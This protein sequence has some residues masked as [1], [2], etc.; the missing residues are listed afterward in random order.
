MG[1]KLMN[2]KET[3]VSETPTGRGPN[4]RSLILYTILALAAII[5]VVQVVALVSQGGS[6]KVAVAEATTTA[7]RPTRTST[8]TFTPVPAT[9]TPVPT[10][11]ATQPP[12]PTA[13][14]TEPT[15]TPLPATATPIPPTAAPAAPTNTPVPP[16]ATAE[17]VTLLQQV[18]VNNGE[19]GSENIYIRYPGN[20]E[21][22]NMTVTGNDGHKYQIEIGFLSSPQSVSRV[23]EVWSWASRGGG[24]WRMLVTMRDSLGGW[25]CDDDDAVCY[26]TDDNP[27]NQTLQAQM[28]IRSSTWRSLIDSYNSGGMM[29]CT[30]N[31]NYNSIQKKI[32]K[33]ICDKC[34]S[35]P[36]DVPVIAF[37]FTRLD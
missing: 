33:H 29:G 5:V 16:T 17:A 23:Q 37:R 2:W 1:R 32:L 22:S 10:A 9:D 36:T 30:T 18:P 27:G 6:G 21:S 34:D 26:E 3:P 25:I 7:Q 8:P 12:E 4:T 31:G 15:A 13:T 20:S 14:P 11:T 35:I 24:N 28:Y 19:Y